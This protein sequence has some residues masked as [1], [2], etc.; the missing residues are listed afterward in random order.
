MIVADTSAIVALLDRDERHHEAIRQLFERDDEPWLLP[1]AILPEV[2]YLASQ[3]LGARVQALWMDDLADG[4]YHVHFGE[5]E[6]LEHARAIQKKYKSLKLGLV[7]A[8][9]MAVAESVEASAIVTLD[10]R[11]FGAVKLAGAPKLYP[12]DLKS[13]S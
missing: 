10:L 1:W 9:V 8:T 5:D 4:V 3:R 13:S 6:D 11:H 7:D 12:R 2:D